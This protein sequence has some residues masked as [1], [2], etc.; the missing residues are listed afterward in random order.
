MSMENII[1]CIIS[2]FVQSIGL[3]FVIF[4]QIG[5]ESTT[6]KIKFIFFMWLY[7]IASFLYIPNQLRFIMFIITIILILYFILK[8]KD[9]I[10]VMYQ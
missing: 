5:K 10:I 9:K 7:G 1:M 2:S 8:I 4:K 3:G 6:N